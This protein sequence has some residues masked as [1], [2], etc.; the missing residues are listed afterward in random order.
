MRRTMLTMALALTLLAMTAMARA[1]E[2]GTPGEKPKEELQQLSQEASNPVGKLWM[3]QNQFNFNLLKCDE[4]EAFKHPKTQFNWN[5]QPIMPIDVSSAVRMVVR[6]VIPIYNTPYLASRRDVDYKSGLG[7]I[8]LLTLFAPNTAA[9]SGFMWGVGPTA[10]FPTAAEKVLGKGKWQLGGA[11]AALYLD[12]KWVVGVFGQHWW[13]VG[14]DPTRKEVSFTNIQYFLWYSPIPTW[15]IGMG[16]NVYIDWT[17]TKAEDRLNL[18]IGL[19]ISKIF[20]LGKLPIKMA[21]E[22][23]YDVVRPRNTV[24]NEWTFRLNITPIIRSLF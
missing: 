13:S 19:G 18:P 6:P 22:V 21:F 23:D 12:S 11:A 7:D 14:G 1:S 20:R 2:E 4:I 24:G 16:P 10:V 9:T 3:L 5:F 15:Q 8:G 17:Q